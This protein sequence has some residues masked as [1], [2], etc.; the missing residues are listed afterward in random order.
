MHPRNEMTLR[1]VREPAKRPGIATLRHVSKMVNRNVIAGFATF[2]LL[3]SS[4]HAPNARGGPVA[5]R[6]TPQD[7]CGR[8]T[9][10]SP[11][12]DTITRIVPQHKIMTFWNHEGFCARGQ[13]AC[14]WY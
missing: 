7:V 14:A 4:S 9:A 13:V 2:G 1:D 10:P 3:A 5:E 8:H 12:V 11:T 6:S